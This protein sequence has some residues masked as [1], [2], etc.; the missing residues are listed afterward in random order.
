MRN[1]KRGQ[2]NSQKQGNEHSISQRGS[3]NV[4]FDFPR[5]LEENWTRKSLEP[6]QVILVI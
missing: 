6:V 4:T 2:R 3:L 1:R 5:Y